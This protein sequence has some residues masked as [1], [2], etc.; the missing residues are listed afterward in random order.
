MRT[1]Q[2]PMGSKYTDR[3]EK[4][5]TTVNEQPEKANQVVLRTLKRVDQL[6]MMRNRRYAYFNDRTWME[7]IDDSVKRWNGYVEPRVS[8][9]DWGAK[10]INPDTRNK[11]IQIVTRVGLQRMRAEMFGEDKDDKV[12]SRIVGTLYDDSFNRQYGDVEFLFETIEGCVKGTVIGMETYSRQ[13]V[14]FKDVESYDP[15][16]GAIEFK[17]VEVY[18]GN[19]V[20]GEIVPP[21]EFYPGNWGTMDIQQMADCAR[22]ITQDFTLFK[23]AFAKYPA[24][25]AGWVKPGG[26]LRNDSFFKDFI[27]SDLENDEV[28]VV[29]Y[30]NKVDDEMVIY[31][32]GV[33]LTPVNCPL[34][35]NHKKKDKGLPFWSNVFEPHDTKF[36]AGKSLPDKLR[37]LQDAS[38]VLDR[39]LLDQTFLSIH[40]PI[41]TS[42]LD[43]IED[44]LM[45]PGRRQPVTDVNAWKELKIS[46]P[47]S[48]HFKMR[49]I[50]KE[51]IASASIEPTPNRSPGARITSAEIQANQDEAVKMLSIFLVMMTWGNWQKAQLR[52]S[53]IMQFYPLPVA[54][55][56]GKM[57]YR[58]KRIDGVPLIL[59]KKTGDVF[60]NFV[61]SKK[62]FPKNDQRVDQL[63]PEL[64]A[65]FEEKYGK[66][67]TDI[68]VIPLDDGKEEWWMTP[69]FL[70]DFVVGIKMIP[71]S[72]VKMS[73]ALEKAMFLE[74]HDR[75]L[76]LYP[77]KI[78][79][80]KSATEFIEAWKKVPEDW[81]LAEDEQQP[82]QMGE[83]GIP[84][85]QNGAKDP[86][87]NTS[88]LVS[89]MNSQGRGTGQMTAKKLMM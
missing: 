5:D 18:I 37:S 48:S 2:P 44:D 17:D 84:L 65:R 9:Q 80:D 7:Y 66:T 52:V 89:Q 61:E 58:R 86:R 24:V 29:M 8:D 6:K 72:S 12:R 23:R 71:N 39:M 41:L 87:A 75:L 11:V 83:D 30:F 54:E 68:V 36:F 63:T 27:G 14:K 33:L 62:G 67:F 47:N 46:A 56:K 70:E 88:K 73:E 13:K 57:K 32:N 38:D 85:P 81:L 76:T 10:I 31:A 35:W 64:K 21:D 28:Q 25:K 55:E 69:E 50:L 53:N 15:T 4:E 40:P 19:E 3:K 22:I 42:D 77:D 20:Y 34:P 51:S 16:T 43:Q 74:F 1:Q 82:E 59:Q 26:E 49:Q 60:I 78:N 79:R 45:R